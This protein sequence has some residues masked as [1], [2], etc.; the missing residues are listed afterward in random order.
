VLTHQPLEAVLSPV[1]CRATLV[2][3]RERER[4]REKERDTNIVRACYIVPTTVL[5]CDVR[6]N[7]VGVY[8]VCVCACACPCGCLHI[9]Y[10]DLL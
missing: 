6:V 4:E 2:G 8:R 3:D 1:V 10:S 7:K 9:Y 5:T